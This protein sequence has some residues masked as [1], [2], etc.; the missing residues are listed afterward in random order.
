M[1][2]VCTCFC[3]VQLNSAHSLHCLPD[4]YGSGQVQSA[5]VVGKLR[6]N[7]SAA[8]SRFCGNSANSN[9]LADSSII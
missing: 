4:G 9:Y 3:H 8:L 1:L 2:K 7:Y 5:K 6:N